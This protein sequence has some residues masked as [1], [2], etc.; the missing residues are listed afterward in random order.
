[1]ARGKQQHTQSGQGKLM[2]SRTLRRVEQG[3]KCRSQHRGEWQRMV[4]S[5]EQ[6]RP[7]HVSDISS[8]L[9]SPSKGS[10]C[11]KVAVFQPR[12]FVLQHLLIVKLRL[13]PQ[14]TSPSVLWGLHQENRAGDTTLPPFKIPSKLCK[15]C[16]FTAHTLKGG[17]LG[18]SSSQGCV[19]E[20][21]LSVPGEAAWAAVT[22]PAGILGTEQ[23]ST[24]SI[25][26][27]PTQRRQNLAGNYR[28]S[29]SRH[30]AWSM[31][32]FEQLSKLS[33]NREELNMRHE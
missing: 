24:L 7:R 33:Q 28:H 21:V 8:Q 11:V 13:S 18:C 3:R 23:C 15:P 2:G 16:M 32:M 19:P 6:L 4:P 9:P 26:L 5:S 27:Q 1:M 29:R 22:F 30:A 14:L 10:G 31:A 20:Q 17:T 12:E 25:K